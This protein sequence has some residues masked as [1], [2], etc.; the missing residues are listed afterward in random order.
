MKTPMTKD[1][2][3]NLGVLLKSVNTVQTALAEQKSVVAENRAAI[4]DLQ[5]AMKG[6]ESSFQQFERAV[7]RIDVKPLHRK[8][9]RLAL[10]ADHWATLGEPIVARGLKLAA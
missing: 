4:K 10:I 2:S 6:L 1:R 3:H 9:M 7:N 8:S 5:D